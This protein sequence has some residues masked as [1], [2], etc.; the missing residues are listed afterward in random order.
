MKEF[1]NEAYYMFFSALANRTRLAIIDLL[2]DGPKTVNEISKALEQDEDVVLE[3]LKPL[4]R[5]VAVLS[6]DSGVKK[7]YRLNKAIVEPLSELLEFHTGKYC[8][9]FTKC[10]PAEK[11]RE[12]LKEEAAR[13]TY[14]EHE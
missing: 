13:T 2:K 7:T 14:I 1:S 12:Y 5:C 11:L 3:N 4:V 6:E 8:P 9:S 10:I